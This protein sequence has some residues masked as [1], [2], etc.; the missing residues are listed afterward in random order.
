MAMEMIRFHTRGLSITL[1]NL[2]PGMYFLPNCCGIDIIVNSILNTRLLTMALNE[3]AHLL[4]LLFTIT[5]VAKFGR[6][7][8]PAFDRIM[9]KEIFLF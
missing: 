8:M 4:Q 9:Y 6:S 2:G 5:I 1:F 7:N 3:S